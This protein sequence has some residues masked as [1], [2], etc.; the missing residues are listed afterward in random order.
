MTNT[1]DFKETKNRNVF[2]VTNLN[3]GGYRIT[4]GKYTVAANVTAGLEIAAIIASV[5]N[6]PED[7]VVYT[8]ERHSYWER[9]PAP[10]IS[11][12]LA[13]EAEVQ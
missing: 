12:D 5:S 10:E 7:M 11:G 9:V 6:K 2:I 3:A 13:L 8:D 4:C 1:P